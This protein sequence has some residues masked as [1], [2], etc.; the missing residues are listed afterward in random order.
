MLPC[1]PS[2]PEALTLQCNWIW[3]KRG[4]LK[5]KVFGFGSDPM[6]L[7]SSRSHMPCPVSTLRK[8]SVRKQQTGEHLHQK[9][10]LA[11]P[12]PSAFQTPGLWKVNLCCLCHPDCANW[13]ILISNWLFLCGGYIL[14]VLVHMSKSIKILLYLTKS[15]WLTFYGNY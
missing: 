10:S 14:S 4:R 1:S 8:G 5:N 12:W 7:E 6:G 13:L 15:E 11:R 9:L 3:S 2:Y